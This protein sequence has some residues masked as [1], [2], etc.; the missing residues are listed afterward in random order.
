MNMDV[1]QARAN[2]DKLCCHSCHVVDAEID[3]AQKVHSQIR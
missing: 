1:A 3:A 2:S